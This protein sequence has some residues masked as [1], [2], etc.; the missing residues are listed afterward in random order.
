M[1]KVQR[2]SN[3]QGTS[4]M[5]AHDVLKTEFAQEALRTRPASS[6]VTHIVAL[7]HAR[8]TSTPP[9]SDPPSSFAI[10]YRL[11][12]PQKPKPANAL[13]FLIRDPPQPPCRQDTFTTRKIDPLHHG[14]SLESLTHLLRDGSRG[15]SGGEHGS[16][17]SRWMERKE[18]KWAKKICGD[19]RRKGKIV[20]HSSEVRAK[21]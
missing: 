7:H 11:A 3:L 12:N 16:G 13:L 14:G 20:W 8:P 1:Q 6:L 18:E 10:L 15:S 4:K 21:F 5:L 19:G 17:L 9:I 2:R